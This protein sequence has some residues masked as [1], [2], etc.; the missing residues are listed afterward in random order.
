MSLSDDQRRNGTDSFACTPF[1]DLPTQRRVRLPRLPRPVLR[2]FL[3]SLRRLRSR[4][5]RCRANVELQR[6][7]RRRRQG[8]MVSIK[9]PQ[10]MNSSH[11]QFLVYYYQFHRWGGGGHLACHWLLRVGLFYQMNEDSVVADRGGDQAKNFRSPF[12]RIA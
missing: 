5:H 3:E 1:S 12:I 8:R 11:C 10:K 9:P 2:L 7:I 6:W 4:R